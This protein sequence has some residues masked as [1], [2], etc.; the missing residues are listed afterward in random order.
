MVTAQPRRHP[1]VIVPLD[2]SVAARAALPVART[3]A[4]LLHATVHVIH[5]SEPVIP[6]RDAGRRLAVSGPGDTLVLHTDA[7]DPAAA[8]LEAARRWQ[9]CTIV[10]AAHCGHPR[11][12]THLGSVAE[13]VLRSATGPVVIV[14]PERGEVDWEPQ[15]LL[16]PLDGTPGSAHAVAHASRLARTSGAR[17]VLLH[18]AAKGLPH[19]Q[20]AGTFTPSRYEDQPQHEWPA[21]RDEFLDRAACQCGGRERMRLYVTQGEPGPETLRVA[22]AEHAD[23][24]VLAWHGVLDATHGDTLR[25]VLTGAQCPVMVVRA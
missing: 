20:E 22:S 23:L 12:M 9:P 13:A 25:G 18:V 21:W 3:L 11:P 7:G 19:T 16:L 2:G 6:P 1:A 14:Q 17:M 10:L 4:R 15:A 24:I 8:I 5:I